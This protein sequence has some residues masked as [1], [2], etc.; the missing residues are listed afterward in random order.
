MEWNAG[1]K[2]IKTIK[3]IKKDWNKFYDGQWICTLLLV[4]R[5]KESTI[6]DEYEFGGL[7]ML[8]IDFWKA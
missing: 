5:G 7:G 6:H 3:T 2:R 4:S 1:V 8:R